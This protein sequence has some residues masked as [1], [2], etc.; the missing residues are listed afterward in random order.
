MVIVLN[1]Q[2]IIKTSETKAATTTHKTKF[3]EL[4]K[5]Q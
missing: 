3:N 4:W 5:M 2:R 1:H